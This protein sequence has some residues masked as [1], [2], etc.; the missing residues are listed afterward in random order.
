MLLIMRHERNDVYLLI[1]FVLSILP[2]LFMSTRYDSLRVED[3]ARYMILS[4]VIVALIAATWIET[5]FKIMDKK[6]K[7]LPPLIMVGLMVFCWFSFK[8]KLDMTSQIQTF[9]PA[10]FQACDWIKT[11]TPKDA[12]FLSLWAAPTAYNCERNA[13]WTSN[14]LSDILLSQNVSTILDGL[15]RQN[16]TYIFIQKFAMSSTPYITMIPINFI[17][18]L[19]TNPNTFIKVYE[20]GPLMQ[21]CVNAG[22]CDG[23]IVYEVKL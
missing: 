16:I 2:V 22:G 8:P 23:T 18:V 3:A 17:G 20:N 21:E 19:E 10:F 9:S 1:L 4:T 12:T 15:K 7:Y 5:I 14:D 6:W 13:R 11:N